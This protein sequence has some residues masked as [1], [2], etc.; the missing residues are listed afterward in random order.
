MRD[1][2]DPEEEGRWE[3]MGRRK[4][5]ETIIR[6]NCVSKELIFRML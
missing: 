3:R 2:K 5:E 1:R 6:I 4:G